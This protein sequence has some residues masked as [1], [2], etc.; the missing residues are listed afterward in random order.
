MTRRKWII[1]GAL[2]FL[3]T[4]GAE[5]LVRPWNSSK[6]RVQIDNQGDAAMDD[7]ILSYGGSK[8]RVGALGTGQSANVWFTAGR[9][10]TLALEFKQKGNPMTGFQVEDFDP[11]ENLANGFK[12]VLVVKN[13]RVERFMDDD[14]PSTTPLQS[15]LESVGGLFDSELP[16]QR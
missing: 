12:V 16:S 2:L 5:L 15:L 4:V 10:G 7:L 6:G 3:L 13:N 14:H 11:A 8:V 1:L 9:K